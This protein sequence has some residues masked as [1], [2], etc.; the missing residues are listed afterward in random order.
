MTANVDAMVRAG[1]EAF[2][3]GNKTEAR[4]LLERALE[5]D[6][7]NEQAWLWLSAVVDTPEEQRTCLENVMVINP[8]NERARMGLKS[9]GFDPDVKAAANAASPFTDISFD[10]PAPATPAFSTGKTADWE[11]NEL[12]PTASSSASSASFRGNT[13]P[14]EY[15][16]WVD[17]LGLGAKKPASTNPFGSPEEDIEDTGLFGSDDDDDFMSVT[18]AT[19]KTT[20]SKA[21][22]RAAFDGE[23]FS[24]AALLEDDS[25]GDD[26]F[27]DAVMDD[28]N[29]AVGDD[30]QDTTFDDMLSGKGIFEDVE[31]TPRGRKAAAAAE[32]AGEDLTP[33]ELF[34]LIPK[35]IEASY[36]PGEDEAQPSALLVGVGLLVVL[37]LGALVFVLSQLSV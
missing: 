32:A 29:A 30:L 33:D 13:S 24:E 21:P 9:L 10:E 28:F 20:S 6:E 18:P 22:A 2:R 11:D 36:L 35:E 8:N 1:V 31:P 19:T 7:Y 16:S 12:P 26:P 14:Q 5:I 15:D 3:G 25:F 27:G 17:S 23:D 4:T 37:N 34:R